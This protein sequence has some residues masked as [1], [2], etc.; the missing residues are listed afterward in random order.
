MLASALA[1]LISHFKDTVNNLIYYFPDS[2]QE[3]EK[4]C[5]A[6]FHENKVNRKFSLK[7]WLSKDPKN[8]DGGFRGRE[9]NL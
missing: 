4:D 1:C 6:S 5:E 9:K 7:N 2:A 8:S 3:T